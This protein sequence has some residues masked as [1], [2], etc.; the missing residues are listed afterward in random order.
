MAP[1]LDL[2]NRLLPFA[3]PGTPLTQDIVHLAAICVLLYFAP[4]MQQRYQARSL[5]A[6]TIDGSQGEVAP[7][8]P[9]NGVALDGH[10][11]GGEQDAVV[12]DVGFDDRENAPVHEREPD[13]HHPALADGNVQEGLGG[14]AHAPNTPAPRN[15]G[16][17]KAKS[18]AR[19]DQRRAYNEFM[20]SQGDA[21]RA[22][23]ARGAAEREGA[24]AT[25]K[26]RRRA[27][28][29]AL[30]ASKAKEREAR[31]QQEEKHRKEELQRRELVLEFVKEDLDSRRICNLFDVARQVG[32][33]V[34][35]DLVEEMLKASGLIGKKGDLLT[36]ITGT[37]WAV[38]VTADDM[39]Q[40]YSKAIEADLRNEEG[41]VGYDELGALL[42]ASLKD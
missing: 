33:D 31:R 19:K 29:Q 2:L 5:A 23:D 17:K 10:A 28:E 42:E 24:L 41:W 26:E 38:R 15:V 6:H 20:R 32:G 39:K 3:T 35:D 4:Q 1:V 16:A 7:A 37:G 14:P 12:N 30:E 36:M 11:L 9:A 40:L 21:Q 13:P 25:E 8:V 22:R 27:A 34:D 18:L